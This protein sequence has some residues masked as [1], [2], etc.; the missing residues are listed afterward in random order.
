MNLNTAINHCTSTAE[1]EGL[2]QELLLSPPYR[3]L[4]VKISWDEL[5]CELEC[6]VWDEH[7][8]Q[9]YRDALVTTMKHA[10]QKWEELITKEDAARHRGQ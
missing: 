9:A 10:I 2:V 1:L 6:E 4:P 5:V 7:V 8:E 3:G